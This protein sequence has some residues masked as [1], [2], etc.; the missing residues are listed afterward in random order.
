MIV[1]PSCLFLL[2]DFSVLRLDADVMRRTSD[3]HYSSY[4]SS[5]VFTIA[6]V[7][8]SDLLSL[9]QENSADVVE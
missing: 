9:F 6:F 5:V 1:C 7:C 4:S 8:V 2:L 3:V